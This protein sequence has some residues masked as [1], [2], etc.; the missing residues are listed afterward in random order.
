MHASDDRKYP[1]RAGEFDR[2]FHR[3]DDTRMAAS[4]HHDNTL[5]PDDRQ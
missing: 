3:I 5:V 4:S 2:M 1:V